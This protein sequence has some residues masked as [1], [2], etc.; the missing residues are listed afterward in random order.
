M[1]LC[2]FAQNNF[3]E[4]SQLQLLDRICMDIPNYTNTTDHSGTYLVYK[5]QEKNK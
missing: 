1:C 3:T 4:N 5:Y 2:N